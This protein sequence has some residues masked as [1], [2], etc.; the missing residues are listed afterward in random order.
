M[1]Y[2]RACY[3][4]AHHFLGDGPAFEK[5]IAALAQ[6]LQDACEAACERVEER[7]AEE[8]LDG[9]MARGMR[10]FTGGKPV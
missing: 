2:D 5:D 7:E 4:L 8:K 10:R 3:D 1:A 6:E 9:S